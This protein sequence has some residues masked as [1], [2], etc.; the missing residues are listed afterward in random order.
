MYINN[1]FWI[2]IYK[3]LNF[4]ICNFFFKGDNDFKFEEFLVGI[5]EIFEL[6]YGKNK[7]KNKIKSFV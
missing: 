4:W 3:N 1:V 7:S 5:L 6:Y 2:R